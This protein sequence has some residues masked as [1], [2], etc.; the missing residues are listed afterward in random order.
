M[1]AGLRDEILHGIGGMLR[2]GFHDEDAI[3]EQAIEQFSD[4]E[5]AN[6]EEVADEVPAL[7]R[8]AFALHEKEKQ[9]WPATTDCDRLDAAFDELNQRGILARHHWWC[10][11]TCGHA[12]MPEERD[13]TIARGAPARGYAFYHA[14]DTEAAADGQGLYL[15]FGA[16]ED[17]DAATETIAGEVVS[18]LAKHGLDTRWDGSVKARIDVTLAWH[19]R[20]RP[21]RWCED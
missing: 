11:Q 13:A 14:Q 19:R 20:A 2:E 7:Y 6:A 1:D 5:D 21:A 9:A 4:D 12:A 8:A 16:F 17:G 15:A 3:L 10:C 18:T